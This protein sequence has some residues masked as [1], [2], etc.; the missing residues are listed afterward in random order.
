MLKWDRIPLLYLYSLFVAKRDMCSRSQKR[1]PFRRQCSRVL[2]IERLNSSGV[3]PIGI[4]RMSSFPHPSSCFKSACISMISF[5]RSKRILVESLFVL[6]AYVI[7]DCIAGILMRV[8]LWW[9]H[10]RCRGTEPDNLGERLK[11]RSS[12]HILLHKAWR[13]FRR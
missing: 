6:R 13:W 1:H 10:M 4:N 12:R 8:L 2:G 7:N 9:S 5:S 3:A 11:S